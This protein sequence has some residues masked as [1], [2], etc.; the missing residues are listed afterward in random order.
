[1]ISQ[2]ANRQHNWRIPTQ[3]SRLILKPF[4][5]EFKP[6]S[7]G[8]LSMSAAGEGRP[9][10]YNAHTWKKKESDEDFKYNLKSTYVV[11]P[12]NYVEPIH[13]KSTGV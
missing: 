8:G 9:Y 6:W 10:Q 2:N 3:V 1:M 7:K 12:D 5:P 11:I 13:S 4:G